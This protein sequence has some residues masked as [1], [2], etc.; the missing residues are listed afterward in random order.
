MT[1]EGIG[2][3]DLLTPEAQAFK[4]QL[5]SRTCIQDPPT[6]GDASFVGS[7]PLIR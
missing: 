7:F 2:M 4:I 6:V 5:D 3:C 1:S